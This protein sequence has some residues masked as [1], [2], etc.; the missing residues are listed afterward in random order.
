MKKIIFLAAAIVSLVSCTRTEEGDIPDN[1]LTLL[2]KTE[3]SADT[4]TVVEGETHVY[5]E[6]GDEIAVFSGEHSG[7][8]V[9]DL[10][11]SSPTASFTGT[12]GEDGWEQGQDLLAVYPYSEKATYDGET[13]TTTL[14]SVQYARAGS[15]GKNM[16]LA[17]AHSTDGTLQ[18]Y[19]VGGGVRFTVTKEGV[20]K[21]VFEGRKREK[22]AGKVKIS[23]N[24]SGIPVVTQVVEGSDII[25]VLPPPGEDYFQKDTWYYFVALPKG[26]AGGYKLRFLRDNDYASSVYTNRVNIKRSVFGSINRADA[27]VE[28]ESL[29]VPFPET[30][31]DWSI[32]EN[33]TRELLQYITPLIK[34]CSDPTFDEGNAVDYF[35][36]H[37]LSIEGIVDAFPMAS[38][39][40][41]VVV[42]KYGVHYN[43]LLTIDEEDRVEG[44]VNGVKANS[45]D[46]PV[47]GLIA[48]N[49][50]QQRCAL[51]RPYH[52][53]SFLDIYLRIPVY[54]DLFGNSLRD[55]GFSLNCID[56]GKATLD[57]FM[58]SNLD[59]YD[60][61]LLATHGS[62]SELRNG[63]GEIAGTCLMT[64][65]NIIGEMIRPS[66]SRELVY[67]LS[68]E[69]FTGI[70]YGITPR[71]LKEAEKM[72]G[73]PSF[74]NTIVMAMACNSYT[75]SDLADYFLERGASFYGGIQGNIYIKYMGA[76]I[77][78]FVDYLTWGYSA[79][80]AMA[81]TK[82]E[83]PQIP[84]KSSKSDEP[85]Y[86]IDLRP[87]DLTS[88]VV[89]SQVSL[90][91][92][93]P[94][95]RWEYAV[96]L[97]VDDELIACGLTAKKYNLRVY[98]PGEH[99]WYL[100]TRVQ[101][102]NGETKS[103]RSSTESFMIDTLQEMVDLGLSVKWASFN[104]GGL[105]PEDVG[106]FYA[107]G[108]TEP[109]SYE[110][111]G[112]DWYSWTSY[113]WSVSNSSSLTKYCFNST[114]GYHGF[115]DNISVLEPEDD[116]AHCHLGNGFRMPTRGELQELLDNCLMESAELGGVTG[117]KFTS[118]IPG[119]TDKWIFIVFDNS[120]S[121]LY[122]GIWSSTLDTSSSLNAWYCDKKGAL[123]SLRR[124]SGLPIR[125]VSE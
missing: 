23:F 14:P 56:D 89:S 103:F 2:A 119:Y 92:K 121:S 84:F 70:R 54:E 111:Y 52:S 83:C 124:P 4:R 109:Q 47:L 77:A 45:D 122:K 75:Y 29:M 69:G 48:P 38:N 51:I 125:P 13:I 67:F 9:T 41:V 91:W 15:F 72:T 88:S 30:E 101:Y 43:V 1:R 3:T 16:N 118:L 86:L 73:A 90:Q 100:E 117:Y 98:T 58:P 25:T 46:I 104:L 10:T 62:V 37:V 33:F 114:N 27:G 19:N 18:F 80:E 115:T 22:I 74:K 20:K 53:V 40:G 5:W 68:S 94:K 112:S 64:G 76:G 61:L 26:L 21:V 39:N 78:G 85:V 81:L 35:I 113:K 59:D 105:C 93:T 36:S 50:G 71:W 123:K 44:S 17:V 96:D 60:L 42:Q 99:S 8:F 11:S 66:M 65:S 55:S 63:A 34:K 87:S 97:Y 108:E 120:S 28:Y 32:S 107:W 116:A 49:T 12:L 106:N 57:A 7:K 31:Q 102:S 24:E 82:K 79:E 6:P 110:V 95:V